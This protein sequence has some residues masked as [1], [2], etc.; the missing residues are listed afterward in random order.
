[1]SKT[2]CN[3]CNQ[4]SKLQN[5]KWGNE[6]NEDV[7]FKLFLSFCLAALSD[8]TMYS[9]AIV[10]RISHRCRMGVT[11]TLNLVAIGV[12]GDVPVVAFVLFFFLSVSQ[13]IPILVK[14]VRERTYSIN[15]AGAGLVLGG[16]IT[17]V[18]D[19]GE[20][21]GDVAVEGGG[22]AEVELVAVPM[23]VGAGSVAGLGAAGDGD[24]AVAGL[25]ERDGAGDGVVVDL[26]ERSAGGDV[27][28]GAAARGRPGDTGGR[29]ARGGGGV[30]DLGGLSADGSNAEDGGEGGGELHFDGFGFWGLM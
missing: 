20:G 30:G 28:V 29:E 6:K 1:M 18:G 27:A 21:V 19:A 16:T 22:L 2:Q 11:T 5:H 23:G 10:A 14:E 13:V 24:G 26:V 25:L 4:K 9:E 12:E 15:V 3:A 8:N 7:C 17:T